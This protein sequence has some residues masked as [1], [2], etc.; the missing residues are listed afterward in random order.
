MRDA[1]RRRR[2]A[3]DPGR[4]QGTSCEQP[5]GPGTAAPLRALRSG[6]ATAGPARES[7][8]LPAAPLTCP[9][10][11][12]RSASRTASCPHRSP[13][14]LSPHPRPRVPSRLAAPTHALRVHSPQFPSPET[15][16]SAAILGPENNGAPHS[17]PE[18]TWR[19]QPTRSEN[20]AGW[21]GPAQWQRGSGGWCGG[22][23]GQRPAGGGALRPAHDGG[24]CHGWCGSLDVF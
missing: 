7:P 17:P 22:P 16:L 9:A 23:S 8:G 20:T 13:W 21:V 19:I 2:G 15:G 6:A 1:L 18:E 14:R 12:C 24:C 3:D 10:L 4:A 11:S 5:R